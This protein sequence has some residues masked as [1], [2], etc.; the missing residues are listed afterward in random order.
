MAEQ[1]PIKIEHHV[2]EAQTRANISSAISLSE[3]G[4]SQLP[5]ARSEKFSASTTD[6][7]ASGALPFSARE[8]KKRRHKTLQGRIVATMNLPHMTVDDSKGWR[9]RAAYRMT[10]YMAWI[11][12]DIRDHTPLSATLTHGDM[13]RALQ[14]DTTN[15]PGTQAIHTLLKKIQE[16]PNVEYTLKQ[17][18]FPCDPGFSL[19]PPPIPDD[20]YASNPTFIPALRQNGVEPVVYAPEFDQ[21]L[22]LW[23]RA[24]E[25]LADYLNIWEGTT[26]EPEAGIYGLVGLFEPRSVR[27]LWPTADELIQYEQEL[28]LLVFD[29]LCEQ[30]AHF[31]ERW[32]IEHM[33]YSRIEAVVL[34][35]TSLRYGTAVYGDDLDMGKVRELKALDIIADTSKEGADPRAQLAARKQAQLLAGYTRES[36]SEESELFNDMARRTLEEGGDE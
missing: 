22:T 14:Q 7:L 26:H 21:P 10:Y 1:S 18:G 27:F 6:L 33:G 25:L 19:F 28:M 35:K 9:I 8:A 20:A 34:C 4:S 2:A 12:G 23:M 24:Y 11:A 29:K 36:A 3:V 31:T 15:M 16:V 5:M 17:E 30:S 32:V 13:P